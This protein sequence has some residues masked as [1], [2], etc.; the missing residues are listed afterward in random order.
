MD[1][2]RSASGEVVIPMDGMGPQDTVQLVDQ[3]VINGDDA[4]FYQA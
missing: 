4:R 3:Q 1:E 2:Q